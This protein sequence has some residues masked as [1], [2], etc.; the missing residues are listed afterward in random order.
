VARRRIGPVKSF[1]LA[2][3]SA[4]DTDDM[5]GGDGSFVMMILFGVWWSIAGVP[6]RYLR[7]ENPH[8]PTQ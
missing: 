7:D 1:R 4:M 2:G 6:E 8:E 5:T 3:R